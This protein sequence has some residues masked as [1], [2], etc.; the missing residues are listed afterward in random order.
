M[1]IPILSNVLK[2]DTDT[3]LVGSL[4]KMAT[5]QNPV[6]EGKIPPPG[7]PFQSILFCCERK[8]KG[9]R[10]M[11]GKTIVLQ[12]MGSFV[13]LYVC[14]MPMDRIMGTFENEQ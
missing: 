1:M 10:K 8:N 13:Y 6:C 3:A 14:S 11:E 4:V 2:G 7:S 5:G 12:L 9:E